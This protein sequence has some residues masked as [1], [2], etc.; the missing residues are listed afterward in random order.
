MA[1]FKKFDLEDRLIDFSIRISNVVD[2]IDS[3]KLGN[4]IAGQLIRSGSSPALNY[5]EAQGAESRNDFIHKLRIVLKE[6]KE[7]RICLKIIERKP[8]I[9]NIKKLLPVLKET[10][11]LIAIIY[12]SIETAQSN[13]PKS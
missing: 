13:K 5:G 9:P 6:L 3:S 12:K 11:E 10:E 2:E 7:S 4:H 1:E 8:L